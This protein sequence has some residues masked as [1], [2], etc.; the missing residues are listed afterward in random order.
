M[1]KLVFINS[2]AMIDESVCTVEKSTAED[3]YLKSCK[4]LFV[5]SVICDASAQKQ[6]LLHSWDKGCSS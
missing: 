6:Q 1:I 4:N 3:A 5:S 2:A